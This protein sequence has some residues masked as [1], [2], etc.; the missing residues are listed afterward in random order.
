MFEQDFSLGSFLHY[1]FYRIFLT[2]LPSFSK[3]VIFLMRCKI[4]D[5]TTSCNWSFH[6]TLHKNRIVN[7][8]PTFL[9]IWYSLLLWY[10]LLKCCGMLLYTTQNCLHLSDGWSDP[11]SVLCTGSWCHYLIFVKCLDILKWK[12]CYRFAKYYYQYEYMS[13][14]SFT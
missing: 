2:I 4:E 10:S 5:L 6:S 3:S 7:S 11:F 13:S 9:W 1:L 12:I 14:R 8:R